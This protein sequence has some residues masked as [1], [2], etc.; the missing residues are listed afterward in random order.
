MIVYLSGGIQG[1]GYD[2]ANSWREEATIKLKNNKHKVLNPLRN[3]MWKD[4]KDQ[5]E[6]Q[7]NE[8]AHRDYVDV[9]R[10]DVILCECTNPYRN[11]WGTITE[12]VEARRLG[13]PVVAFV[14]E[15]RMK[16]DNGEHY[17]YWMDY[18]C[19]KIVATMDEAIKYICEVL[20]YE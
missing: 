10:S 3:R 6:F 7:I 14:G 13:K 5:Q 12:V 1:Y 8:L 19:T 16:E 18:H 17:S 15:N 4:A 9:E 2:E 20:D 11:Y